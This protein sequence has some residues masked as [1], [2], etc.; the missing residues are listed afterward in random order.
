MPLPG[1]GYSTGAYAVPLV[2]SNVLVSHE[3]QVLDEGIWPLE[4]PFLY[5]R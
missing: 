4:F 1:A 3:R 5:R 2:Q